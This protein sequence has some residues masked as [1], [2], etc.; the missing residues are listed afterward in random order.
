MCV[1]VCLGETVSLAILNAFRVP[2][3]ASQHGESE[4]RVYRRRAIDY[5][6]MPIEMADESSI[7]R[8][9]SDGA[10]GSA[11]LDHSVTGD[12]VVANCLRKR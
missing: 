11:E 9:V 6:A 1:C 4:L 3:E 2:R 8:R 12:A 5:A 10:T 7:F